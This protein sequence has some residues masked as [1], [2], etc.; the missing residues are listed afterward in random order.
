MARATRSTVAQV[1]KDKQGD[2]PSTASRGKAASKKRKR[3]SIAENDDQ[4]ATKQLRS[5]DVSIKEETASQEP[6]DK[7]REDT[8]PTLQIAGD[9]PIDAA[10]AQK[11]LDILEM[12]VQLIWAC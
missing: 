1:E 3:S 10:D 2:S 7:L 11:I 12:C 6:E 8:L 4:P 5:G 9:V